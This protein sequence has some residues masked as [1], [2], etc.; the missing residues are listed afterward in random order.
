MCKNRSNCQH[1]ICQIQDSNTY[2][3]LLFIH[4]YTQR[5]THAH[6]HTHSLTQWVTLLLYRLHSRGDCIPPSSFNSSSITWFS[7]TNIYYVRHM[8]TLLDSPLPKSTTNIVDNTNVHIKLLGNF[9]PTYFFLQWKNCSSQWLP[10]PI[11]SAIRRLY[12]LIRFYF[13]PLGFFHTP[14]I[15]AGVVVKGE[16]HLVHTFRSNTPILC[17]VDAFKSNMAEG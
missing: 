17:I 5:W 7:C 3:H 8:A 15:L 16:S 10:I 6:T 13:A 9:A 1:I 4:A 12:H 11:H 14:A 2:W